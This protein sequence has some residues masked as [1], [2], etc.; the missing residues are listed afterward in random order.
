MTAI[1]ILSLSFVLSLL[2]F[3]CWGCGNSDDTDRV[4][5]PTTPEFAEEQSIASTLTETE[6]EGTNKTLTTI[7]KQ[8]LEYQL[9]NQTK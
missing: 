9:P 4:L 5:L 6:I 3:T 8:K 1:R 7:A 2:L